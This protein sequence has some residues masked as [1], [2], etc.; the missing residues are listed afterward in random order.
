MHILVAGEARLTVCLEYTE[1][2]RQSQHLAVLFR[3]YLY[4]H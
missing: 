3:L 2:I 1:P 4:I